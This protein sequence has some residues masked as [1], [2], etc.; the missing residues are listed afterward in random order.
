[1][2]IRSSSEPETLVS[3]PLASW[4]LAVRELAKRGLDWLNIHE[5]GLRA[6]D[7]AGVLAPSVELRTRLGVD[8]AAASTL[9]VCCRREA[10]PGDPPAEMRLRLDLGDHDRVQAVACELTVCDR[11][12]PLRKVAE[13]LD[14]LPVRVLAT[15]IEQAADA[16]KYDPAFLTVTIE[17]DPR[18]AIEDL[19]SRALG[20]LDV[21]LNETVATGAF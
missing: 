7:P 11:R 16:G 19:I 6:R 9:L 18:M 12:K 15:S 1:V 4:T 8:G 14:S 10:G 13:R 20:Q 21:V 3:D 17:L 2:S 5:A